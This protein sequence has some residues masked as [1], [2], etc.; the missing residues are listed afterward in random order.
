MTVNVVSFSTRA[1]PVMQFSTT[2]PRVYPEEHENL[3][4][5]HICGITWRSTQKLLSP[6]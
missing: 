3:E 6:A 2:I 4:T 5:I 1:L